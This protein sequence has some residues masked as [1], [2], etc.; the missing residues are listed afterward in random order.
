MTAGSAT[1]AMSLSE[2]SSGAPVTPERLRA[3]L[4]EEFD[5]AAM[6]AEDYQR[7]MDSALE[8]LE[9][10]GE[11]APASERVKIALRKEYGTLIAGKARAEQKKTT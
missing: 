7:R 3:T 8:L 10:L 6:S 5:A 1:P 2:Y 4:L 11:P 9:S